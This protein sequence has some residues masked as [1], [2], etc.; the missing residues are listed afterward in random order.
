MRTLVFLHGWGCDKN[1][2]KNQIDYFS[3]RYRVIAYDMEGFGEK[4]FPNRDMTIYDYAHS[5][6]ERLKEDVAVKVTL[7]GHSFGG[8]VSILLGALYPELIER[9]VLVSSAGVRTFSLK[10]LIKTYIYKSKKALV[11]LGLLHEI[12]LYHYG[13]EDYK[14]LSP[15]MRKTFQNIVNT[16]LR[17]YAKLMRQPVLLIW[18]SN[19]KETPLKCGKILKR[20][21]K[22]EIVIMENCGHYCFLQKPYSFNRILEAFLEN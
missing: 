7:V 5:V 1:V 17:L 19:D 12:A 3:K 4:P 6:A 22:G 10:R 9:V 16:D 11:K 20:L 15:L 14:N 13:S 21:T 2:W 8:R 18:G